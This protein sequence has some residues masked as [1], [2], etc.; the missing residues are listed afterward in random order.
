LNRAPSRDM[1]LE[2]RSRFSRSRFP[3]SRFLLFVFG[4]LMLA[5]FEAAAPVMAAVATVVTSAEIEAMIAAVETMSAGAWVRA[6]IGGPLKATGA[7][8]RISANSKACGAGAAAANLATAAALSKCAAVRILLWCC[9]ICRSLC[10]VARRTNRKM[11][12]KSKVRKVV[13]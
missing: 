11:K 2:S 3:R 5:A 4:G 7:A 6:S 9:L 10:N 13:D 1:M 8:V 12:A